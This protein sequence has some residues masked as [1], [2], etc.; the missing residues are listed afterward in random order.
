VPGKEV[1]GSR[2]ELTNFGESPWQTSYQ[3]K[4]LEYLVEWCC[5]L[6]VGE[7]KTN[8]RQKI[9]SVEECEE[10]V[11]SLMSDKENNKKI[12][13][14]LQI[15]TSP[16]TFRKADAPTLQAIWCG[17]MQGDT[18]PENIVDKLSALVEKYLP[19]EAYSDQFIRPTVLHE[20]LPR[21]GL[22]V[23]LAIAALLTAH[24]CYGLNSRTIRDARGIDGSYL[25]AEFGNSLDIQIA[26]TG[27]ASA[28]LFLVLS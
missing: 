7:G 17:K 15:I 3:K 6:C 21:K 28:K 19:K 25:R 11:R 20:F 13:E 27:T 23:R 18:N 9:I 16:K 24:C 22:R 26:R 8:L 10:L 2:V 5:R 4:D 14:M 1:R 12:N